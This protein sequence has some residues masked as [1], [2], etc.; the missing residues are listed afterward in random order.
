MRVQFFLKKCS[1]PRH[2]MYSLIVAVHPIGRTLFAFIWITE[3]QIQQQ[4]QQ[5]Q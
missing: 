4:Q 3:E 1:P 5:Q 2:C